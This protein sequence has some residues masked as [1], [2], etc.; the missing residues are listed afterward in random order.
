MLDLHNILWVVP[1]FLFIHSFNKLRPQGSISLS[2]WPYVFFIVVIAT[3]TWLPAQWMIKEEIIPYFDF[4]INTTA[5]T[6]IISLLLAAISFLL[7]RWKPITEFIS[8]SVHDHFYKKCI[9]WKF[10]TILLTLK[11]GKAYIGILWE[12]PE[13][14]RARHESQTISIIP[15]KSG[16][17]DQET[18]NI[19]WDTIYPELED[20]SNFEDL[21]E[22]IIPRSEILTYGKFCE[23]T[24]NFMKA[25]KS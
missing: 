6:L 1:G 18:K 5:A 16:Y 14:P 11:N 7:S 4:Y 10:E 21:M 12:S 24:F 23:K 9:A 25:D 8:I 2:G 19:I 3:F 15:L 22:L 13:N 17:R 20:G